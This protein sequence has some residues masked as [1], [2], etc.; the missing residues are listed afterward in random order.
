MELETHFSSLLDAMNPGPTSQRRSSPSSLS[1]SLSSQSQPPSNLPRR[2]T[3]EGKRNAS[4]SKASMR[5]NLGARDNTLSKRNNSTDPGSGRKKIKDFD[6]A[7]LTMQ[8]FEDAF[9]TR[10]SSGFDLSGSDPFSSFKEEV[11][12]M[13][14]L[15]P[16][17]YDNNSQTTFENLASRTNVPGANNIPG[18]PGSTASQGR[19]PSSQ[20][21]PSQIPGQQDSRRLPGMASIGLTQ[22]NLPQ[23]PT[24]FMPSQFPG[25]QP[26]MISSFMLAPGNPFSGVRTAPRQNRFQSNVNSPWRNSVPQGFNPASGSQTLIPPQSF[27]RTNGNFG[28]S[29]N[30]P[31]G[32]TPLPG[33]NAP[34]LSQNQRPFQPNLNQWAP[35]WNAGAN[36]RFQNGDRRGFVPNRNPGQNLAG[37]NRNILGS[38][39]NPLNSN[40]PNQ[41]SPNVNRNI[42][43]VR[44]SLNSNN[45]KESR[46]TP[47]VNAPPVQAPRNTRDMNGATTKE[48]K[49]SPS[50]LGS[51]SELLHAAGGWGGQ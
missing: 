46:M 6:S 14:D 2:K 43:T 3:G 40:G 36:W 48:G 31:T 17:T 13:S 20:G 26:N 8:H 9:L 35:N 7:S 11:P 15:I 19:S 50:G 47:N 24:Q 49:A 38:A 22:P 32:S 28:G 45:F 42:K 18:W 10:L 25:Q 4:R 16:T 33:L 1:L 39:P 29:G 27:P 44:P 23:L 41:V 34:F 51:F 12:Q 5:G 37:W 30:I 21:F